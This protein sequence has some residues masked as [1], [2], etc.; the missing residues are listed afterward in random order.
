MEKRDLKYKIKGICD[1]CLLEGKNT[2]WND[3]FESLSN[4]EDEY[5][6]NI[7]F[8]ALGDVEFCSLLDNLVEGLARL[9]TFGEDDGT[10]VYTLLCIADIY[11]HIQKWDVISN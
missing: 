6:S 3:V 5:N 10:N 7:G 2:N 8:D 1:Y 9:L 11:R 4:L